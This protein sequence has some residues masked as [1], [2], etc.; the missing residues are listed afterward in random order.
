VAKSTNG[1][2]YTATTVAVKLAE[3]QGQQNAIA[4]DVSEIKKIVNENAKAHSER[5]N[6]LERDL[7]QRSVVDQYRRGQWKATVAWVS[8]LAPVL[9]AVAFVVAKAL[10]FKF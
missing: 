2:D 6:V 10:G 3:L 9:S 7:E 8:L 4:A 5:L 1:K